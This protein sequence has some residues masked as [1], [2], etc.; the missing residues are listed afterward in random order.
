MASHGALPGQA[1]DV[2]K[3]LEVD[4]D[5]GSATRPGGSGSKRKEVPAEVASP[6]KKASGSEVLTVSM[7]RTLLA[8]QTEDL[9]RNC[10]RD[11][12][13]AVGHSEGRMANVVQQ[14]KQDLSQQIKETGGDIEKMKHD[15]SAAMSRIE[16]LE[17][18]SNV[19]AA[20]VSGP[21]VRRPML[22]W[23]GFR[24]ETRRKDIIAD[25]MALLKDVEADGLLD[26]EVWVPASRHSVALSEFRPRNNEPEASMADRMQKVVTAVNFARV[27]SEHTAPGKTIWCAVSQPRSQRGKGSHCGKTRRLLHHIGVGVSQVDCVYSTGTRWLQ[28]V[29]IAS[30]DKPRSSEKVVVG[31]YEGSWV[32]LHK[33]ADLTGVDLE[34]IKSAW[35]EITQPGD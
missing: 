4:D 35:R 24:L 31:L 18:R 21:P 2:D 25:V 17:G 29:V 23:G 13:E 33:I 11:I 6:T 7:L 5:G 14:V 8:E 16:K 26:G 1:I 9:R 19:G 20:A 22:V 32:D 34:E 30:I 27:Q 12:D 28:D 15:L 3:P 10:K